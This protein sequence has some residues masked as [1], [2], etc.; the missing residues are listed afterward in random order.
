MT[1]YSIGKKG[2]E[3]SCEICGGPHVAFTG[4]LGRF[5]IVKEESLGAGVRRIYASVTIHESAAHPG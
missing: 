4:L 5:T 2:D 3:F 1:V